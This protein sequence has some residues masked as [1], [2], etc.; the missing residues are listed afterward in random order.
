MFPWWSLIFAL[1]LGTV[2]S[3]G[4]SVIAPCTR[5]APLPLVGRGWG[6]G[7]LLW[8]EARA[9][10]RPPPGSLRSPPSPPGGGGRPSFP[11]ALIP[12][13]S[14]TAPSRPSPLN[15]RLAHATAR[16][17]RGRGPRRPYVHA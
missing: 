3:V 17:R 16:A 1:P 8:R 15:L 7:P 10:P 14:L 13:H 4:L 6:W 5:S 9:P 12:V 11:L 2:G